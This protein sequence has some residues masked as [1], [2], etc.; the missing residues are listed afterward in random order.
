MTELKEQLH[1]TE[2]RLALAEETNM[3]Q[4]REVGK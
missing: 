2:S 3:A 4:S 1:H